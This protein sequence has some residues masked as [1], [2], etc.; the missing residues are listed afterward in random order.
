MSHVLFNDRPVVLPYGLTV[1]LGFKKSFI[2]QNIHYWLDHK[3]RDPDKYTHSYKDGRMWLYRSYSKWQEEM[4]PLGCVSSIKKQ[5]KELLDMGV[6]IKG[7]FNKRMFDK[8]NWYTID[9]QALD[10]YVKKAM[11]KTRKN[12]TV[13]SHPTHEVVSTPCM[14]KKQPMEGGKNN[15]PIPKTTHR[16]HI[17]NNNSNARAEKFEDSQWHDDDSAAAF[18]RKEFYETIGF[19]YPGDEDD[20]ELDAPGEV[21]SDAAAVDEEKIAFAKQFIQQNTVELDH[22]VR[23]AADFEAPPVAE[24]PP[25]KELVEKL[26]WCGLD[27]RT[28]NN[29]VVEHD[30]QEIL[31]QIEWLPYRE[32]KRPPAMLRSSIEYGYACPPGFHAQRQE[33]QQQQQE[34]EDKEK[35][36]EILS[37][38]KVR[39]KYITDK[40]KEVFVKYISGDFIVTGKAFGLTGD[41]HH[42]AFDFLK[43]RLV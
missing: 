7:S 33:E 15:Q 16:L 31:N 39:A 3:R 38:V 19:E 24:P 32:A 23:T 11:A 17:E 18:D 41:I 36:K 2:V 6:L 10:N 13:K 35:I 5:F 12:P 4:P 20:F 21:E 9:Y 42:S 26:V 37:R 25:A 43:W 30:P 29:L 14:D 28:A 40:G 34:T 27:R 8:T 22:A 1:A